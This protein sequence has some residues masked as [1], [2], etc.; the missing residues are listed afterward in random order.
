MKDKGF[1]LIELLAIILLISII[2]STSAYFIVK[3]IQNSKEKSNNLAL[4]NIK[5][6]AEDYAKEYSTDVVWQRE[7][8]ST[9][10][11]SCIALTSLVE[12]GYFQKKEIEQAIQN[13]IQATNEDNQKYQYVIVRKSEDDSFLESTYDE[14]SLCVTVAEKKKVSLPTSKEY[15]NDLTYEKGVSQTLTKETP[16]GF[17]FQEREEENAGNY[18]VTAKLNDNYVWSD[19]SRE[20][21]TITCSIKKRKIDLVLSSMGEEGEIGTSHIQL[22]SS[23]NGTLKLKTSDKTVIEATPNGGTKIIA[24]Q[25]KEINLKKLATKSSLTYLTLTVSPA[26]DEKK[27]YVETSIVYTIGKIEKK[28]VSIPTASKNCQNNPYNK[29]VQLLTKNKEEGYEFYQNYGKEIGKYTIL[30]KL[31]YGY[32]WQEDNS[33]TD[34][35]IVC[36]ITRPKLKVTYDSRGGTACDQKIVNYDEPYGNL[37]T[38][39]KKGYT[40]QGWYT[41]TDN[42]EEVTSS[43]IVKKLTDHTLYAKWTPNNYYLSFDG[44]NAT[45]GNMERIKC[46]YDQECPLSKNQFLRVDY[47]FSGWQYQNNI[48]PDG[49]NVK[50]LTDEKEAIITLKALWTLNTYT[51]QF[52][53]NGATSGSMSEIVCQLGTT[54]DLP[55]N[56]FQKEGHDFVGWGIES[57]FSAQ[58][59]NEDKVKNLA[60]SGKSITLYAIWTPQIYTVNITAVDGTVSKSRVD[61]PYGT[62]YKTEGNTLTIGTTIIETTSSNYAGYSNV[63]SHWSSTSGKITQPTTIIAYHQKVQV[64]YEAP[65]CGKQSPTVTSWTNKD[66]KITIGC[67][68][69]E[70]GA[71]CVQESYT[72][73]F[74]KDATIGTIT[75]ED[76]VGNKRDCTVDVKV[77]KT[78]PT[79]SIKEVG[80][81]TK[82]TTDTRKLIYSGSSTKYL[83]ISY[84]DE[85]GSGM[86]DYALRAKAYILNSSKKVQCNTSNWVNWP[87]SG[88]ICPANTVN[89]QSKYFWRAYVAVDNAGNTSSIVCTY[90]KDS[91]LTLKQ[92]STT[93]KIQSGSL[94]YEFKK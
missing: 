28:T 37:C 41:T 14:K 11:Y 30:A 6:S 44:N 91:T 56:Q 84:H 2:L 75:I 35:V 52:S 62:S 34:K 63:F 19:D 45:S 61:V 88:T 7:E 5:T 50:N 67:K 48:F 23:V 69:N 87:K 78:A 49:G 29:T 94:S 13:Q 64:D 12:K 4:Q 58:Y 71:G 17:S 68:D 82:E 32:V 80:K 26:E 33:F 60:E 42:K 8:N 47:K 74:S 10:L 18:Q 59:K 55:A 20:N 54:C 65:T 66:R 77:D 38:P 39:V 40:F 89:N 92:G 86:T 85:G 27:N 81:S 51:I 43:T 9:N 22:T 57:N 83:L 21:K 3:T 53:G 46:T 90:V 36:E 79:I 70:G 76:L 31:Q 1:S 16:D 72:V 25:K 24:N 93:C 73:T 15:C